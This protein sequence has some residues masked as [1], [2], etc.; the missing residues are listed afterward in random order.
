LGLLF[1]LDIKL[2]RRNCPSVD[3]VVGNLKSG[4][5]EGRELALESFEIDPQIELRLTG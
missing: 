3:A 4:Y 2:C 1:Q 5:F